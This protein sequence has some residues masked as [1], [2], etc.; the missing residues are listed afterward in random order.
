MNNSVIEFPSIQSCLS[1]KM[2][3]RLAWMNAGWHARDHK[4]FDEEKKLF[5][6]FSCYIFQFRLIDVLFACTNLHFVEKIYLCSFNKTVQSASQSVIIDRKSKANRNFWSFFNVC[7]TRILLSFFSKQ[8]YWGCVLQNGSCKLL[9][10]K[11][12]FY[13]RSKKLQNNKNVAR[14][15]NYSVLFALETTSVVKTNGKFRYRLV[16]N[17]PLM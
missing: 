16:F 10:V 2:L 9:A 6:R 15:D 3:T 1:H 5:F 14:N 7:W 12:L 13:P 4:S 11:L 8:V 17:G